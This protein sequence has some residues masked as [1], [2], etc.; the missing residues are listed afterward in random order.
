MSWMSVVSRLLSIPFE[1]ESMVIVSLVITTGNPAAHEIE[2]LFFLLD[3]PHAMMF[4]ER[5][6]SNTQS[7]LL[8]CYIIDLEWKRANFALFRT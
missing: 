2:R 1:I 3:R 8:H 4:L 7:R 5:L 6:R